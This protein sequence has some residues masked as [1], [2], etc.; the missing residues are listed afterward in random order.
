VVT[1]APGAGTRIALRWPA[2][3]GDPTGGDGG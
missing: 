1:S 2:G 3:A